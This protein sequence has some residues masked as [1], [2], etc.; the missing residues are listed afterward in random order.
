MLLFG[1]FGFFASTFDYAN[2]VV[3]IRST[4]NVW[5]ADKGWAGPPHSQSSHERGAARAHL[6][7]I[8]DPF[9]ST[10]DLGHVLSQE[11]CDRLVASV[12]QTATSLK[13]GVPLEELIFEGKRQADAEAADSHAVRR[14]AGEGERALEADSASRSK[15]AMLV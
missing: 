2:S 5:K 6:F 15:T 10:H 4:S 12:R 7:A 3:C 11:G 14:V 13:R 9:D 8:E 1:F